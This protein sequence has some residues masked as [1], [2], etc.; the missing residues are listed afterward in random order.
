MRGYLTIILALSGLALPSLVHSQYLQSRHQT[1]P[2]F[3][4]VPGQIMMGQNVEI[5]DQSDII[6]SERDNSWCEVEPELRH[7][8]RYEG[9]LKMI[10]APFSTAEMDEPPFPDEERSTF[11]SNN[12]YHLSI[13]VVLN[14]TSDFSATGSEIIKGNSQAGIK[15]A[16]KIGSL[17]KEKVRSEGRA[18]IELLGMKAT[19]RFNRVGIFKVNTLEFG[20]PKDLLLLLVTNGEKYWSEPSSLNNTNNF[21]MADRFIK[22][23]YP[24]IESVISSMD[25]QGSIMFTLDKSMVLDEGKIKLISRDKATCADDASGFHLCMQFSL[26]RMESRQYMSGT[27]SD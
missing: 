14:I 27:N 19:D 22:E 16:I 25:T 9:S 18:S 24:S 13:P 3:E 11:Y 12:T 10:M 23:E 15:L 8:T 4:R 1:D 26:E 20:L 2:R 21:Y 7:V 17:E 5:M 6:L